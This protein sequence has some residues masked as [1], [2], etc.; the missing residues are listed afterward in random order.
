VLGHSHDQRNLGLNGFLDGLRCLVAGHVDG[1]GIG[2][3]SLLGLES[4]SQSNSS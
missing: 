1:R 3:S 4:H 2:L